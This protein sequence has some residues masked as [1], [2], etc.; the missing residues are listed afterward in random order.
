MGLGRNSLNNIRQIGE[1]TAKLIRRREPDKA[2]DPE[3][4]QVSVGLTPF[5][6]ENDIN[7]A[8]RNLKPDATAN[9]FFDDIKVNNFAQRAA[10]VNAASSSI[11][12]TL[13]LNEGLYATTSKAYA[14]VLG[15]SASA[16]MILG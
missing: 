16:R 6:R 3:Y 14:E 4:T 11:L 5:V 7:F 1:R 2:P 15:T 13:R 10:I 12:S 8:A 9:L